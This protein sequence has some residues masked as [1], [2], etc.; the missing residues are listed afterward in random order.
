MAICRNFCV[1]KA[2]LP[3]EQTKDGREDDADAERDEEVDAL[4]ALR[5]LHQDAG[6]DVRRVADVQE[7][8]AEV[9][10]EEIGRVSADRPARLRARLPELPEV[11]DSVL[12]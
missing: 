7:D 2:Y 1:L 4:V 9:V 3:A 6:D 11:V 8:D 5:D 12:P 10:G